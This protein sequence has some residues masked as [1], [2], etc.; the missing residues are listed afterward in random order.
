MNTRKTQ[1]SILIL[2][3]LG[4]YLGLVLVGATPQ[5]K[6]QTVKTFANSSARPAKQPGKRD[7]SNEFT[8]VP[9]EQFLYRIKA[10]VAAQHL[11]L[12]KPVHL[13]VSGAFDK[14]ALLAGSLN[15]Q[16]NGENSAVLLDLVKEFLVAVDQS[17][18]FYTI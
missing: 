14:G 2:T 16:T 12:A 8:D 9:L 3:T 18:L 15:V 17:N 10:Q 13:K 6:A 4:V 1:N 5:I 11:D 7:L